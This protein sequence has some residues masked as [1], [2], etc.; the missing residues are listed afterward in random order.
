MEFIPWTVV[1]IL[2]AKYMWND[3]GRIFVRRKFNLFHE[4]YLSHDSHY[5]IRQFA[6]R[7]LQTALTLAS[8]GNQ[9]D[10]ANW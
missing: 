6:L 2:G 3:F 4:C 5:T 9:H 1:P 7:K 8:F 10:V